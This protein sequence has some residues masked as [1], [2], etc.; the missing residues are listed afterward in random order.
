MK[1]ELKIV[2]FVS[3][4][5]IKYGDWKGETIQG[6]RGDPFCKSK[7]FSPDET[8]YK[9]NEV[10]LIAPCEPSKIVCLGLNYR[11]H[12][13]ETGFQEPDEPLMFLKPSTSVIGPEDYVVL[14][15]F[16]V[17]SRIDY[18][19]EVGV[20]IGKEAKDVAEK[21]ALEYILGYTCVNDVSARYYQK[22][23]VQWTRAK[24]FDTFCPIGP[25]IANLENP[26]K[27]E[28]QTIINGQTRQSS[29]TSYLIFSI[30]KLVSFISGVMTLLPGDVI[31]TGTPEGIGPM[32]AGDV[33]E[34]KVGGVG[35]LKNYVKNKA[36]PAN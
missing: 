22:K 4:G 3:N 7:K 30:S 32:Q 2:R 27:I 36:E 31:S 21:D 6:Y 18:E 10:K 11:S 13:Q 14:P 26:D 29:D 23:D 25:C 1:K 24:G 16:A 15:V 8:S 12:I 17:K 19:G 9:I 20:V 28:V 33:V 34:I 35:T 5:K